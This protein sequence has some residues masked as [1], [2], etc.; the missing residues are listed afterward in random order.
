M[1][2][3]MSLPAIAQT[4]Y[5]I[6]HHFAGAD[7]AAPMG[8]LV[9]SGSTLYGMT[10]E[11]GANNLGTIFRIN[12]DG[13][14]FQVLRSF[15]LTDG[16][17]PLSN[18]LVAGSVL[19]GM[20]PSGGAN[21]FGVVFRL[22]TDGTGFQLLFSFP[23]A[24][25]G[26]HNPHGALIQSGSVFYGAT[27]MGGGSDA[28]TVFSIN[29]DGTG[30]RLLHRFAGGTNDGKWPYYATLAQSG[31][32]LFGMTQDGGTRDQGTIYRVDA[33]TGDFSLVRNFTGG[34]TD[35]AKPM[36][37]LILSGSVLYGLSNFGGSSD[38]GTVFK[39]N[40]DGTGFQLLHSFTG[41]DGRRA[42]STPILSGTTLYGVTAEGGSQDRGTIFQV[43]TDGT[44]FQVLHAFA[45]GTSD[46][47]RG[48]GPL[49]LSG[50][51]L[52]GM[53]PEGG[54]NNHGVI[55]AVDL[56]AGISF[57]ESGQTFD[58]LGGMG[59]AL[60]DLNGDGILDAFVVN[61]DTPDGRG[62]RVYFGDGRGRFTDSGQILT[63]AAGFSGKPA[64][65]D[66]SGDGSPDASGSTTAGGGSP[67]ARTGSWTPM[68]WRF[69]SCRPPT[70]TVTAVPMLSCP[71]RTA[72][73]ASI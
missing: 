55:F 24:A 53:T 65:V 56:P 15:S 25:D 69:P 28:G 52:Y 7:G 60:A 29:T 5:R 48:N 3:G 22:N 17:W 66:V 13:T 41:N 45:G 23:A 14:G 49:L 37:S 36:G 11:G 21:N 67:P 26:A 9:Q 33:N 31:S 57:A 16:R 58:P 46:G 34:A 1:G 6:L 8:A 51:T 61:Q 20:T 71:W 42:Y 43:G 18:L 32:L 54:S 40:S 64:I 30:L 72:P 35:A 19:Y 2:F 50:S 59:V 39:L 10:N 62:Y 47:A 63:G 38:Y 73:A 68:A 44:N 12:T 27:T 4:N 70:S